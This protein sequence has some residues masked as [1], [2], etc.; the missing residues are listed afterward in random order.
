MTLDI[1]KNPAK[2]ITFVEHAVGIAHQLHLEQM[3]LENYLFASQSSSEMTEQHYHH[4]F[5]SLTGHR[6][7][8]VNEPFAVGIQFFVGSNV[9]KFTV[10]D[11][12]LAASRHV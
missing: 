8:A 1:G 11:H 12:P 2:D 3:L 4:Q 7:E 6:S 9:V 5:L 10:K